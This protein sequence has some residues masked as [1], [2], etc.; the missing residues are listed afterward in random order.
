MRTKLDM[1]AD[2]RT[3]RNGKKLPPAMKTNEVAKYFGIDP[4]A[5]YSA[6]ARDKDAP[7][8]SSVVA[9]GNKTGLTLHLWDAAARNRLAAWWVAKHEGK[10]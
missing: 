7:Q 3:F 2:P 9:N 1:T 6:L 4:K 5:L 10:A 8:P